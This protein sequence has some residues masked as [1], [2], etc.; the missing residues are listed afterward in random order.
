[1]PQLGAFSLL[2]KAVELCS[3]PSLP[4]VMRAAVGGVRGASGAAGGSRWG[5][6]TAGSIQL[7]VV[8][9]PRYPS[10]GAVLVAALFAGAVFSS[11]SVAGG[12]CGYGNCLALAV[13][14]SPL[15]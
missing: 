9:Y 2:G 7:P 8:G 6:S 10:A 4:G 14:V 1:M 3:F 12:R 11:S 13:C 5:C 15:L